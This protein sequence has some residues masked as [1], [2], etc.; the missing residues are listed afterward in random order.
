MF[1]DYFC[2]P[3]FAK[4]HQKGAR[5]DAKAYKLDVCS[6]CRSKAAKLE[7]TWTYKLF[8]LEYSAV[9]VMLVGDGFREADEIS[10]A[11]AV[12]RA[13]DADDCLGTGFFGLD[14]RAFARSVCGE[15]SLKQRDATK[16]TSRLCRCFAMRHIE[17]LPMEA[18][19]HAP[20]KILYH[21]TANLAIKENTRDSSKDDFNDDGS[22]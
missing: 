3:C 2:L 6:C 10:M 8:C 9:M 1:Q 22:A 11:S 13:G 7:C 19:E 17:S 14:A 5:K 21:K 4:L 12:G 20:N 16:Q 18:R 15:W